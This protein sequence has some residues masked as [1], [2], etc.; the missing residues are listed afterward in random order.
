MLTIIF[1]FESSA[2]CEAQVKIILQWNKLKGKGVK[3]RL[4][5]EYVGKDSLLSLCLNDTLIHAMYELYMQLTAL[6]TARHVS[7]IECAL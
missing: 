4:I 7:L 1:H 5:A 2:T 3:R 6:S